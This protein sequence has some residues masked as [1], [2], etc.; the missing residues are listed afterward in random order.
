MSKQRLTEVFIVTIVSDKPIP[1][2]VDIVAGR[3]WSLDHVVEATAARVEPTGAPVTRLKQD[4]IYHHVEHDTAV[5]LA[6]GL[7]LP[8]ELRGDTQL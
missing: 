2:L 5:K 8:H 4:Q 3:L 7:G 1:D 6:E